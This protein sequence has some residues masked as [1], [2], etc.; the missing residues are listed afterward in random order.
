MFWSMMKL[1]R[2]DLVKWMLPESALLLD[3]LGISSIVV[4]VTT[5]RR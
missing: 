3:N 1:E 5:I 2:L 4:P